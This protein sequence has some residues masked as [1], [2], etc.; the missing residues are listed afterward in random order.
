[1]F[2]TNLDIAE[3]FATVPDVMVKRQHHLKIARG[4]DA[5]F[6]VH[7]AE[8]I[9]P[10]L[11]AVASEGDQFGFKLKTTA[12]HGDRALGGVRAVGAQGAGFGRG[13]RQCG[14]ECRKRS[15]EGVR[16]L[17]WNHF[18]KIRRH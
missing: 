8:G 15:D 18:P 3:A 6:R 11:S 5:V 1:L 14:G 7:L 4:G 16:E 10:P 13:E 2:Q 17:V 9:F 12:L